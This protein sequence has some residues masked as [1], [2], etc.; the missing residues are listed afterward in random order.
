MGILSLSRMTTPWLWN[1]V[2][3]KRERERKM[4]GGNAIPRATPRQKRETWR[5]ERE[6]EGQKTSFLFTHILSYAK[7]KRRHTHSLSPSSLC[8]GPFLMERERVKRS[9]LMEQISWGHFG[10]KGRRGVE[11]ANCQRGPKECAKEGEG[12][13]RL[14]ADPHRVCVAKGGGGWEELSIVHPD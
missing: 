10:E 2:N 6:R 8:P 1:I 11:R 13:R 14:F 5:R 3:R 7:R 12:P 4:G 9:F